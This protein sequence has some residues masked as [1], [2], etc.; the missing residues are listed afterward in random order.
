MMQDAKGGDAENV[1]V[2][3]AQSQAEFESTLF[4]WAFDEAWQPGL[5]D[6]SLFHPT[7]PTGFFVGTLK[8]SSASNGGDIDSNVEPVNEIVVSGISAVKYSESY[9]FLGFYIV[10]PE[11]RGKGFG[12]STWNTAMKYLSDCTTIGLD[13]VVAQQS[14]YQKSGFS[15]FTRNIRYAGTI[16]SGSEP[17]TLLETDSTQLGKIS[18]RDYDSGVDES[19]LLQYDRQFVP[20]PRDKFTSAWVALSGPTGVSSEI[21]TR[22]TCVAETVADPNSRGIAGYGTVR[23]CVGD[24]PTYRIGP[25]FADTTSIAHELLQA[26]VRRVCDCRQA[27]QSDDEKPSVILI[28]VPEVNAEAIELLSKTMRWTPQFETARMYR[29]PAPN[30]PWN[31]KFGLTTL[32]LG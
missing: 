29:G 15:L 3:T 21:P 22:W 19:V 18:I 27:F 25:L 7:D 30:L 2:R 16:H 28:D 1:Q 6:M 32:E 20:A 4:R 5:G 8:H 11:Y 26:L 10:H 17:S 24:E 12:I 31:R 13:G 14:N 23:K 9:A